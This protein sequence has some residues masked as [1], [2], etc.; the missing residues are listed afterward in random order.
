MRLTLVQ[1]E[2]RRFL[3]TDRIVPPERLSQAKNRERMTLIDNAFR[4]IAEKW[5]SG[6]SISQ[7]VDM[8]RMRRPERMSKDVWTRAREVDWC[9]MNQYVFSELIQVSGSVDKVC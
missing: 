4:E 5:V 9:M 1:D 6:D 3:Q 2:L 7:M 8:M